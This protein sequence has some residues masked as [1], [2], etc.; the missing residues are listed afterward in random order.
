MNSSKTL[1]WLATTL[2]AATLLGACGGSK[3]TAAST[4]TPTGPA[5]G[6]SGSWT[7]ATG[8]NV[9]GAWGVYGTQGTPSVSTSPGSRNAPVTWRD[10]AGSLW[11]FGGL[12][13]DTAGSGGSLNDL[14]KFAP[15]NSE[16]TWVG[17]AS[18]VNP[19]GSYGTLGVAAGTSQPGGRESAAS[20]VD[21]AGNLWLFGGAGLDSAGSAGALND[22]WEYAAAT[23]QW[24]WI[25]GAST[26]NAAG[27]YGT[28]G[29]ASASNMP[30]AREVSISWTD[31]SGNFWLFGGAGFD[32]T[33][34][35]G[36]L[37]DLW[38]FSP[39]TGAW[40]WVSGSSLAN[41]SGQ[42]GVVGVPASSNSPGA[43]FASVAWV[44]TAG[45]L[46]LFGGQGYDSAGTNGSLNDLWEF[47]PSSGLWTWV[48]GVQIANGLGQ[49]GTMGTA[50]AG[51]IPGARQAPAGWVDASGNF[52][53]FGGLGLDSV[54]ANGYLDDLWMYSPGSG[55]WTWVKGSSTANTYGVYGTLGSGGSGDIPGGRFGS[56]GWIDSSN[57]LWL[58]GGQGYDAGGSV[59]Y[60][61]DLWKYTP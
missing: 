22:L 23:G 34:A 5:T 44:D 4:P 42:Y 11:L 30:G 56:R 21:S 41:A 53:L 29:V 51:N 2:V 27:T 8:A 60:L 61:N 10:A 26:I 52:W 3:S 31:S 19:P 32:S 48:S 28:R 6:P 35:A 14:W 16:W 39:A 54:A 9:A 24:A 12:G 13:Y 49:Y 1:L 37:N 57:A 40:K 45:N 38:E 20:W 17:G 15:A 43:R 36:S 47:T 18:T 50:A 7:W 58:F 59:S 33:G 46:W 55:Q 25:G